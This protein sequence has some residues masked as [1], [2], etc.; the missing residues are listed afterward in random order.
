MKRRPETANEERVSFVFYDLETSGLSPEFDQALQFAAIRTDQDLNEIDTFRLRCRLAP[1]VVP[2]PEALLVNRVTPSMLTDP[3]FPSYYEAM[4]AVRAKF[5]EW[6]PAIFMGYNSMGFDEN[7]L[8]QGFYQ[9][10]Q[11]TYLTNTTGNSRGDVL[12][13]AHALTIYAPGVLAVPT[14]GSRDPVY[15]LDRL[16]P[17]NGYSSG[18]HHEAMADVRATLHLA[19][20]GRNQAAGVWENMVRW[21]KKQSV[22]DFVTGEDA[23]WHSAVFGRNK[24]YSWLVTYCGKNC[25]RNSQLAVF[26]LQFDPEQ[27]LGLSVKKLIEVLNTSPRKIRALS[28]N[29]QPILMPK[30]LRPDRR[31][32]TTISE[33]KIERISKLIRKDAGFQKR[34][35]KALARRF[36]DGVPAQFPEQ[37]IYDGFPTRTDEKIMDEFHSVDWGDRLKLI[38]SLREE[39]L[40]EFGTRLVYLEQPEALP[41]ALRTRLDT[42]RSERILGTDPDVPWMTV[43]KALAEVDRLMACTK[44]PKKKRFL[45]DLE[46][47]IHDIS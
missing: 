11:P 20:L 26:D 31:S 18:D 23:V 7:F 6:S 16:A 30:D 39:R 17:A 33:R 5:V 9:T 28:A 12:R 47:F 14:N 34:V 35:S 25:E 46:M 4:K 2:S 45:R 38:E 42:W 43:P 19:R 32:M 15:K 41:K 37:R 44:E 13:V 24:P 40:R 10:L 3:A 8:R 21:T 22:V 29:R 1:H 27:L 36:P